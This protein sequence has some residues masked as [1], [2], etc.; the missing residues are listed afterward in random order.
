MKPLDVI[1]VYSNPLMWRRRCQLAFRWIE[2]QLATDGVRLTVVEVAH[3]ERPFELYGV[4]VMGKTYTH[5]GVRAKTMAWSKESAINVGIRA[6]PADAV[7]VCWEDMDVEHVNHNWAH[8]AVHALQLWP[9]IQPWNEA[10]DLG[11]NGEIMKVDNTHVQR[12]LASVYRHKDC[13][14]PWNDRSYDGNYHPGYSWCATM[15]FLNDVGLLFDKSGLGA[16]DHQMAMGIVGQ[17]D[18]SIHGLTT[19]AYQDAVKAWCDRAHR[20]SLGHLGYIT[21]RIEHS[22]HGR[23]QDREYNGRWSIL[24]DYGFDPNVDLTRNRW[25]IVEVTDAK[26]AMRR[27]MEAY[28]Q[29]RNEDVNSI[30]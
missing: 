21:G 27:A 20:I 9:V 29:R 30:D 25:G 10:L 14:P 23:K 19:K 4:N 18:R 11:P 1:G 6:L 13:I 24:I 8:A 12:S 22:F 26:P 2:Q 5:I 17:G 3:G 28:Y 15:D 16:A 7:Y